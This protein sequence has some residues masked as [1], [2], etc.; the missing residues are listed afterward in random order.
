MDCN[1]Y[2]LKIT[3]FTVDKELLL[4]E[5]ESFMF[6]SDVKEYLNLKF[7]LN[8]DSL[9]YLIKRMWNFIKIDNDSNICLACQDYNKIYLLE[10]KN[11]EKIAFLDK[12]IIYAIYKIKNFQKT[13]LFFRLLTFIEKMGFLE[14]DILIMKMDLIM[15]SDYY[16]ENNFLISKNL[17]KENSDNIRLWLNYYQW[18]LYFDKFEEAD[19]IMKVLFHNEKNIKNPSING[20][21]FSYLIRHYCFSIIFFIPIFII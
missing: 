16:K 17:L 15:I 9:L 12:M 13:V 20:L 7:L 21:F 18:C 2:R 4:N 8:N 1:F 10:N 14:E 11:L 3:N 19:K 6:F 5:P